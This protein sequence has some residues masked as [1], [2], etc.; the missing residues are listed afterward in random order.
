MTIESISGLALH[1]CYE[2]RNRRNSNGDFLNHGITGRVVVLVEGDGGFVRKGNDQLIK[3]RAQVQRGK[4]CDAHFV[5]RSTVI[6]HNTV[7]QRISGIHHGSLRTI[8]L[9]MTGGRERDGSESC[10]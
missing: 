2:S 3:I 1:C 4:G 8:H 9:L 5:N 6:T 10:L 7:E